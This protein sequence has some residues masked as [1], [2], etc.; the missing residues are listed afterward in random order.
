MDKETFRA[1]RL[2]KNMTQIEFGEL[3]GVSES[4]IAA[5]ENG[6]RLISDKVRARLATITDID[7]D[8]IDFYNRF[9]AMGTLT[10]DN[11]NKKLG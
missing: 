3:L 4:T 2:S 1:L 10:H 9:R 6:R 7:D 5:I 11:I 8:F